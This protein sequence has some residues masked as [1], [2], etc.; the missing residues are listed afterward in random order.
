MNRVFNG[1][2]LHHISHSLL[3]FQSR[4]RCCLLLQIFCTVFLHVSKVSSS[5][6]YLFYVVSL[7]LAK[8]VRLFP[9]LGVY[10][11]IFAVYLQYPSNDSRTRT[12]N[13]VFYIICLLY[14][15]C[16]ASI[17]CDLLIF[18]FAVSNKFI[19]KNI[20]FIISFSQFR[21]FDALSLQLQIELQAIFNRISVV[22]GTVNACCDFTAQC[23]I[24]RI[25]HSICIYH[26]FYSPESSKIYR[27]WIVWGK[28]IPFVII[29]SFLAIT[30]LG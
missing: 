23:I 15:F 5:V 29:P 18:I 13:V 7:Y 2:A 8:E 4:Q 27:C 26:L 19:C 30:L 10:S 3:F 28:K 25:N 22:Q 11:G 16:V 17:V 20:I 6:T 24:V 9:G 14:C 21:I 1:L 12:A